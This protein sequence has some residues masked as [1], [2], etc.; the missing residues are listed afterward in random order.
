MRV[1]HMISTIDYE[2]DR[3]LNTN[4]GYHG[5]A[6]VGRTFISILMHSGLFDANGLDESIF[7][8]M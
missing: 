4:F 5:I 6:K 7:K 8:N 2:Y 3:F 1:H